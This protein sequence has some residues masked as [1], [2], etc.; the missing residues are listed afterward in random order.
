MLGIEQNGYH[1]DQEDLAISAYWT[2]DKVGDLLP[3][4]YGREP[5][6]IVNEASPVSEA[7]VSPAIPEVK[8]PEPPAVQQ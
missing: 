4:D 2:W 6:K 3:Y 1:F 7:V 8:Q 5:I